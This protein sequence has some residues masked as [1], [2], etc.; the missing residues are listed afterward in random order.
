MDKTH[1]LHHL[2]VYVLSNHATLAR[3]IFQHLM[4]G[5]RFDLLALE[6]RVSVIE[7]EKDR[8]LMQLLDKELRTFSSRSFWEIWIRKCCLR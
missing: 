2:G 5:L 6:F 4:K 7:V 1:H 3:D 8:A